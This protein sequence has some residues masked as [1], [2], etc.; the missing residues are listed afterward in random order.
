MK[1]HPVEYWSVEA[2][3]APEL[4]HVEQDIAEAHNVADRHPEIVERLRKAMATHKADIDPVP[5]QLAIR[6]SN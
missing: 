3:S 2:P 4:Y 5:D 1:R 6:L